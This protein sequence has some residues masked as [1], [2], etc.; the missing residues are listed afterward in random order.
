MHV[1]EKLAQER[2]GQKI[3][4]EANNVYI[5][6]KI[7][8]PVYYF[9]VSLSDGDFFRY[10]MIELKRIGVTESKVNVIVL[11][12]DEDVQK[13]WQ[14]YPRLVIINDNTLLVNCEN[15]WFELVRPQ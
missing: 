5:Y 2:L 12:N 13:L 4:F 14:V 3:S 7:I 8:S 1:E 10:H 9:K 15:V 11:S 6:N